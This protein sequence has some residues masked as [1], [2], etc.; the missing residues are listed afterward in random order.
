MYFYKLIQGTEFLYK[1]INIKTVKIY[2]IVIKME[3]DNILRGLI[4]ETDFRQGKL[5]C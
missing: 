4:K 1:R 2:F 5:F 3:S